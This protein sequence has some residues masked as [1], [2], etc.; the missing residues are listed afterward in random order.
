MPFTRP[1]L[2]ALIAQAEAFVAAELPGAELAPRR[3]NL[4]VL[5]RV[6]AGMAHLE[7]GYLD[8]QARN[9]IP[10]T[11]GAEFLARWAN[12]FGVQRRAASA[13][14]GLARVTADAPASLA[15]GAVLVRGDGQR[16]AVTTTT[17]LAAGTTSVPVE[18][19]T[20]GVAGNTAAGE[21]LTLAQAVA[22]VLGLATV[23]T[24]GL[25]GG[26]DA[27]G[28]DALRERLLARIRMPPQ[29]GAAHDYLAWAYQ[30]PGVTRAFVFPLRRGAGTV[31]VMFCM[32]GRANPIPLSGDV[33]TMQAHIDYLRPVTADV[34]VFAPVAVPFDVGLSGLSENTAAVRL[35]IQAEIKA[36]L[37]R[38]SSPGGTIRRSRLGEAISRAT[39]EVYHTLVSPSADVALAANQIFVPGTLTVA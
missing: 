30:I 13:A 23:G 19:L 9:L 22:G 34:L 2:A 18:A 35:A 37:L 1:T 5:A 28:D 39:G 3:A 15:A 12:I 7:Y 16:F 11:A 26:Q 20:G 31:D 4:K 10:D 27:E 33:A 25:T 21:G 36:L 6:V 8:W 24:D 32:D 38:D 29:G 17:S 14:A